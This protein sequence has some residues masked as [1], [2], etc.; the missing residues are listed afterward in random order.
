MH[1]NKALEDADRF[2]ARCI[3]QTQKE[4][5]ELSTERIDHLVIATL[6]MM[7]YEVYM[8]LPLPKH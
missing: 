4:M 8:H 6:L 2:Y 5:K 7:N 1:E 3:I